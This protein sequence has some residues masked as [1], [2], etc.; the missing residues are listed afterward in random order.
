MEDRSVIATEYVYKTEDN[1]WQ[2]NALI[3]IKLFKRQLQWLKLI[4]DIADNLYLFIIKCPNHLFKRTTT[5]TI[6]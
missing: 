2:H 6:L 3:I 5:L 1:L 4:N